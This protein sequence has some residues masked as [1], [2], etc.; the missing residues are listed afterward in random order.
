MAWDSDKSTAADPDNPAAD[1]QLTA[2]EWDAHVADQKARV[3]Y[4]PLA[5]RPAAGDVPNG[6]VFLVTDLA[7]N[8]GILTE[9]VSGTWEIKS[10]GDASN[11]IPNVFAES[12]NTDQLYNDEEPNLDLTELARALGTTDGIYHSEVFTSLD[13]FNQNTSG[14][15]SISIG[16]SGITLN[17]GST[18]GS[19]CRINTLTDFT[20][21][22]ISW[23]NKIVCAPILNPSNTNGEQYAV[24]GDV[25]EDDHTRQHLGAAISGGDLVGTVADGS[26]E[27]TEIIATS[28]SNSLHRVVC[29]LDPADNEA[30][31]YNDGFG[32]SP[33]ATITTNLPSGTDRFNVLALLCENNSTTTAELIVASF[34][35]GG[36]L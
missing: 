1:E 25:L 2:D 32:E 10:L 16:R 15:G 31:F 9:V 34:R 8:G 7:N 29:V 36:A 12:V 22:P 17:T 6:T 30:R 21:Y 20:A 3:K 33:D 35:M 11:R 27:S 5:D 28:V 19:H 24:W 13:G 26:T 14:S 23:D 18:D 4:G